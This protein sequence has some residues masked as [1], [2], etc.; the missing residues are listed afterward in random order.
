M[1][2]SASRSAV[3]GPTPNMARIGCGARNAAS[4][5]GRTTWTPP[6]LAASVA[7]LATSFELATPIEIERPVAAS[8]RSRRA[9]AG[10][11]S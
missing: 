10:V 11:G 7:I 6:G 5:P 9:S 1:P 3:R 8:T 2:A 4:S